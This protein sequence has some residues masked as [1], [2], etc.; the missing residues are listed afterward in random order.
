[1]HGA[2]TCPC[3]GEGGNGAKAATVGLGILHLGAACSFPE[4]PEIVRMA[5]LHYQSLGGQDLT[6]FIL[7][8]SV[9]TTVAG[10]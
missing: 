6:L 5:C 2:D 1:M 8:S 4:A 3:R 9:P 7:V 10:S